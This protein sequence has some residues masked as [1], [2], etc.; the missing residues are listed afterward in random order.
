MLFRLL[1]S[2]DQHLNKMNFSQCVLSFDC[3]LLLFLSLG[4]MNIKLRS[5]RSRFNIFAKYF[6]F[7][8]CALIC[9]SALVQYQMIQIKSGEK[10]KVGTSLAI[11]GLKLKTFYYIWTSKLESHFFHRR[12]IGLYTLQRRMVRR[13]RRLVF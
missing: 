7:C 10:I 2:T 1:S 5:N 4:W 13:N 6:F 8:Y 12:I 3:Q 9:S 11:L